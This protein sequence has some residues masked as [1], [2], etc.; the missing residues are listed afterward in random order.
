[1]TRKTRHNKSQEV[2]IEAEAAG[3]VELPADAEPVSEHVI[4]EEDELLCAMRERDELFEKYQRA[5]A[6]FRN[7]QRRSI[8]NERSAHR[9][10]EAEVLRSV[11]LVLDYF[12][13]A[14][15]Q[16]ADSASAEQILAGVKLIR[17]ELRRAIEKHGAVL[18]SPLVNE[19]FNAMRHEAVEQVEPDGDLKPGHVAALLQPGY[20]HGEHVL[21]PA[22]VHVARYSDEDEQSDAIETADGPDEGVAGD[23]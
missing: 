13:M 3:H 11:I 8:E 1:M 12:D 18:I 14:L 21:R 4:E 20:S 19:E 5:L 9:R 15:K 16:N 6:D 2:D 22:K 23:L 7:Y 17:D 10:G